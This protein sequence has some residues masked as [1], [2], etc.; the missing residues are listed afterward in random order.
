MFSILIILCNF[1]CD[2]NAAITPVFIVIYSKPSEIILTC[3]FGAQETLRIINWIQLCC[4]ILLW[5]LWSIFIFFKILSL[6]E[7]LK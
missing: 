1:S 6:I 5:K 7:S 2:G 3:W 4:V